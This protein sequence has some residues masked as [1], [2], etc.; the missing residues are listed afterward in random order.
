MIPN[1]GAS[2][3]KQINMINRARMLVSCPDQP[4]IVAAVSRFLF[5]HGANIIQS[6]QYTMEPAEGGLFFIRIEFDLENLNERRE[7]T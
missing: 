3:A 6:D 7:Q 2:K 4:G 1:V 5:E